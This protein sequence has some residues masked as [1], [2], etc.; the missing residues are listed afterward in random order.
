MLSAREFNQRLKHAVKALR[1]A[2]AQRITVE[3]QAD[4]GAR[5]VEAS[6]S[7]GD[8]EGERVGRLIEERL[9]NA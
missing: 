1:S 5:V 7:E 9:G 2:G 3:I 8:S 4:G 6:A